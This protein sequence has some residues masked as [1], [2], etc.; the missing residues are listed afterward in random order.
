M[1]HFVF[2]VRPS[3]ENPVLLLLDNHESHLAIK[4]IN[5]A[6]ENN[7][8]MLSFPPHCS[9]RLQPLDRSVYGPFKKYLSNSQAAWLRNNP[10]KSMTIYDIPSLVRDALPQ[11]LTPINIMK[12]F[13]V[14]GIEPYNRDIFTDD[15]FLP[16]GVTDQPL[17][18][19]ESSATS[20]VLQ[21]SG[22][23]NA[24][25]QDMSQPSTSSAHCEQVIPENDS[26]SPKNK[27]EHTIQ[28]PKEFSPE[29]VRPFPKA[30][31]RKPSTRGR[32]KRKSA[33]L[34]DTPEKDELEAEQNSRKSKKTKEIQKKKVE[35]AKRKVMVE[36][37][38]SSDEECFCLVC[39]E[40]FSRSKP[41]EKWI[42][43]FH[44]EFWSYEACT[45]GGF[46]YICHNCD[47]DED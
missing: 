30:E 34:T 18:N 28:E 11:A 1:E 36:S 31:Q 44:C 27:Q 8:I 35:K 42:K 15:E 37:D 16:A 14:S 6:K 13:K 24:N 22:S 29:F 17:P 5:F 26:L 12:G 25:S 9:H 21:L 32:K 2:H 20:P 4:T 7:V 46:P 40:P 43:C 23:S 38:D 10:G 41:K 39:T 45:D 3:R 47:S 33:V 19:A